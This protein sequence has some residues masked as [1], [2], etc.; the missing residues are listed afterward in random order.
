MEFAKEK[1]ITDNLRFAQFIA[2]KYINCGIEMEELISLCYLGMTKAAQTYNGST[3]FT[4][5]S[6]RVMTNEILMELRRRKKQIAEVSFDQVISYDDNGKELTLANMIPVE[7]SGFKS[8]EDSVFYASA[9][10]SFSPRERRV[11]DCARQGKRQREIG[12]ILGVSQSYVSRILKSAALKYF[13]E[14]GM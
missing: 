1:L 9:V 7:E 4:T 11:I 5:Y 8:A 10:R 13:K 6:G 12:D 14:G 2:N 3:K